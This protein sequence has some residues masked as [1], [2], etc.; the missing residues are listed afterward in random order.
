MSTKNLEEQPT[1]IIN[2]RYY[3]DGENRVNYGVA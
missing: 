1:S 3:P 2:V